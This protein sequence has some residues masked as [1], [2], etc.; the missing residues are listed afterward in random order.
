MFEIAELLL[1]AASAGRTLAVATLVSTAGSSP[2]AVGTSMAFDGE[3]V[4]G[5]IAGG[6]VEGA[7][8]EVC[9]LV[10][11]DGLPRTEEYG[12]EDENALSVGLSC[13]GSLR[14]HVSV[15][16]SEA[17]D[18]LRRA[19]AGAPAGMA[20][21][22]ADSLTAG[23]VTG[24]KTDPA[25][26]RHRE[27]I[28]AELA[29]RLG[30]GRM[31]LGAIDCDGENVEVFFE[32]S[33]PRARL[34]I[35]GATDFSVALSAA[36]QLLGFRVTVCDPRSLFATGAR[37]PGAEV[38]VGWPTTWFETAE[39]DSRTVICVLSHDIRFDAEII[40][41]ALQSPA[42]FVGAMGSR[43]THDRRTSE[44]RF[45]GVAEDDLARLR[46]PI[47]LDLGAGTVEETAV[48]ILA[49]VIAARSQS[50]AAPLS[51]TTGAIHRM[52]PPLG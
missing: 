18:G 14:V 17:L 47:G 44:L 26:D 27:K 4:F 39:I 16:T 35:F 24:S 29:S 28:T 5:S 51:S 40:A 21:V 1:A 12:V 10:L 23:Q 45:R 52:Q 34:I 11:A 9:Q 3:A 2:R 15:L 6:C 41:L 37:L 13:G 7:I 43:R 49:E 30:L 42:G 33:V 32:V 36:A 20:T 46:S 22:L 19:V 31:G 8:V 38:F 50:N 25:A 48:A